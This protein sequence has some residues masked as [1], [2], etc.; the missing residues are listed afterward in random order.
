LFLGILFPALGLFLR[1]TSPP[2]S[3]LKIILAPPPFPR[4]VMFLKKF[5]SPILR[6]FASPWTSATYSFLISLSPPREEPADDP[7]LHR[8]SFFGFRPNPFFYDFPSPLNSRRSHGRRSPGFFFPLEFFDCI[9]AD[10]FPSD[11]S[12]PCVP[13]FFSFEPTFSLSGHYFS[14]R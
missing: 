9:I 5:L 10:V 7:P 1:L 13:S 2:P 4:S 11:A 14:F 12:I 8:W 3:A 6:S